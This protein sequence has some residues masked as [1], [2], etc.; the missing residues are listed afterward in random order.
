[1]LIE[2][3][4]EREKLLSSFFTEVNSSERPYKC[5]ICS[6]KMDKVL[7]GGNKEVLIDRCPNTDGLWFDKGEL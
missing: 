2:D 7:V 5:P 1:M 6:K 3:K 4:N